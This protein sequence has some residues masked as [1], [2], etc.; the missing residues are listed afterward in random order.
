MPCPAST[1]PS[2]PPARLPACSRLEAPDFLSFVR[3]STYCTQYIRLR[4]VSPWE[5]PG[6]AKAWRGRY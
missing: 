2:L 6:K 3:L 1:R 5:L 4:E